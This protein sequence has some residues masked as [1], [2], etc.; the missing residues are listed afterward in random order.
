MSH[1]IQI[2]EDRRNQVSFTSFTGRLGQPMAQVDIDTRDQEGWAQIPAG[3]LDDLCVRWLAHRRFL[4][5]LP[6]G[7][8][9]YVLGIEDREGERVMATTLDAR[10]VFGESPMPRGDAGV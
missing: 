8:V 6:S 5:A 1:T 7:E 3:Q 10:M 2:Y 4:V 9:A